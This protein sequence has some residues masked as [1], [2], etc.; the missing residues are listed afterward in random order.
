MSPVDSLAT[1]KTGAAGSGVPGV[2]P[3]TPVAVLAGTSTGGL[4]GGDDATA[5]VDSLTI[6]GVEKL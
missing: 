2:G 5:T 4:G 3:A 6:N 1:L